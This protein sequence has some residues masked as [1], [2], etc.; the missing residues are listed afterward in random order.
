MYMTFRELP[1]GATARSM[2][3]NGWIELEGMKLAM[4]VGN[5]AKQHDS[6]GDE[7][8]Y[9]YVCMCRSMKMRKKK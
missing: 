2:Y 8:I 3:I 6:S 9:I 4:R 5:S 7:Y 1:K